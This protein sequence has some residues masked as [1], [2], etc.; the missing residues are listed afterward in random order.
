[1]RAGALSD[2]RARESRYGRSHDDSG[3]VVQ[4]NVLRYRPQSVIVRHAEDSATGDL[5]RVLAAA[6]AAR[7]HLMLST[8]RPLPG[9]LTQLLAS[10]RSPLDVVD[11]VVESDEE[12]LARAASGAVFDQRWSDPD[13]EPQDALDQVLSQSDDRPR[14]TAFGGPGSRIRLLGGDPLALEEALGMSVDTAIH[15]APVVESG[16]IEMLPFLREQSV[17]ITA[18]R[19]GD[20]D[21]DFQELRV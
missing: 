4:R 7:A 9:P 2:V 14:H 15:D 16:V 11:H 17:S 8:S 5:V 20:L 13:E 1:M 12:F 10:A 3:L 21:P 6:T 19:F 18:H